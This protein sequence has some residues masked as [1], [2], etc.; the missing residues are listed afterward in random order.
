MAI[1]IILF[2][3]FTQWLGLLAFS[4]KAEKTANLPATINPALNR[5]PGYSYFASDRLSEPGK[6]DVYKIITAE[7]R[8]STTIIR[9]H[10]EISDSPEHENAKITVYN[11]S[12]DEKVGIY[13]PNTCTGNYLII[14]VPNVKYVFE[15]E[16]PGF[17][18]VRE[19]VEVP[20]KIDYETSRQE[21]R[22]K[23]NESGKT[24]LAV[25]NWFSDESELIYL[26]SLYNDSTEKSLTEYLMPKIEGDETEI[27]EKD[28]KEKASSNIDKLVKREV[29]EEEK[30][31]ERAK[32]AFNKG[33][34]VTALALYTPLLY[35][36]PE[37]PSLNYYYGV[38]LYH[39]DPKKSKA[40]Y[41]LRTASYGENIP[42]D[43]FLYL[44]KSLYFSYM[45]KDGL[46]AFEEYLKRSNLD[47]TN[48]K[49]IRQLIA[50][51]KNGS[52]L[53]S[54]QVNIKVE[55][56]SDIDHENLLSS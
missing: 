8:I 2:I 10:F 34:Y 42:S 12:N 48:K 52:V 14:L 3:F 35:N 9:G 11:A 23:K 18:K 13:H 26:L 41:F 33:D 30:K 36:D 43:V 29:K 56:R 49:E 45:F 39:A 53:M 17:D 4:Q 55:N 50:N 46:V 51:C 27:S 19:I 5:N 22:I 21:I 32:K 25:N 24:V 6:Y 40:I 38:S 47:E 37:D 20:L 28:K 16:A 1:K 7:K 31:P 44:G 15:V 54:E